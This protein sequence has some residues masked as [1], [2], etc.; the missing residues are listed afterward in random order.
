[1]TEK[2]PENFKKNGYSF[3]LV[4]REKNCV[5]YEQFNE[6]GSFG[7]V[8]QKVRLKNA[9][10]HQ[11]RAFD[12]SIKTIYHPKREILA[13]NEEYGRHAW[14]YE[15]YENALKKMEKLTKPKKEGRK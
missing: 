1:M 4:K 14:H 6:K 15:Q 9:S 10:E 12:G 11:I 13:S 8:T 7:W 2:I 3:K 5:I